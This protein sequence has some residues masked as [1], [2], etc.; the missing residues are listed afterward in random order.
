M[1]CDICHE[2][3]ATIRTKI[4]FNDK[5]QELNICEPCAKEHGI[6]NLKETNVK[7]FADF[8]SHLIENKK[9]ASRVKGKCPL[10]GM[11]LPDFK[12]IGQL[13]C[14]ECYYTFRQELIPL[15]NKMQVGTMHIGRGPKGKH[16]LSNY[17][18]IAMLRKAL[19]NAIMDERYEDA[20]EIRDK[21]KLLHSAGG[22]DGRE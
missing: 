7:I 17:E 14:D 19:Q 4:Y 22:E 10:C 3:E 5:L 9:E 13:G 12:R 18:K 1:K 8:L 2:N 21:L 6:L 20:A 15:F 11:T 16:D